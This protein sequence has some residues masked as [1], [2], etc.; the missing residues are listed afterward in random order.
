MTTDEAGGTSWWGSFSMEAGQTARGRIGPLD[1]WIQRHA[2]EWRLAHDEGEDP[3]DPALVVPGPGAPEDL[4]GLPG[5]ERFAMAATDDRVT[6]GA[7]LADRPVISRPEKPFHL[8]AG[9]EARVFVST[10]LWLRFCVGPEAKLLRELPIARPS[11]TW[12]GPNTLEGELC[13]TSRAYFVLN[14]ENLP[15]LPHRAITAV[16]ILNKADEE[17][18]VDRMRLPAPQLAL[19]ATGDGQVWTQDVT[20][21]RTEGEDAELRIRRRPPRAAAD[22]PRI[23]DPRERLRGNLVVRTFSSLFQRGGE[24]EP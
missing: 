24:E 14:P 10:P 5:V 9:E 23:A 20:Y 16:R 8:P 18:T 13:Y 7:A 11:D 4:D 15:R 2:N 21:E 12:F 17:L 1:L 6:L 19:F 3:L 22:A